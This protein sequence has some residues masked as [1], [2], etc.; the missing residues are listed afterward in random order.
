MKLAHWIATLMLTHA[1]I[2]GAAQCT[3]QSGER[4]IAL[5]ELYTS[6]GCD[7]CP[8]VDRWV[9]ALPSRGVTPER[10]VTLAYHVDYWNYIGWP[11][12]F[13]QARFTERQRFV[14]ARIRSRTV[15]TPQL[16]LDGKDYRRGLLRDEFSE[17]IA[18]INRTKPGA[19]I[20]LALTASAPALD[21]VGTVSLGDTKRNAQTFLALYENKLANQVTA[22][23]NKGKRLEHDFVVRELAG[24]L[25]LDTVGKFMHQFKIDK[26]WKTRDITVAAFVQDAATGEVLQALV[27][28]WCG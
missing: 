5:L 13:A 17:Q 21:V 4:R 15:Y 16:M 24:P 11:D 14:N 7:S 23:E 20:R 27:A 9:S 22:G 3:A 26:R 19:N 8:P 2:A 12:P 10:V 1:A 25:A 18:A 6:E 28:P